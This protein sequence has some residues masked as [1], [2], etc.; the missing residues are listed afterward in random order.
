[1]QPIIGLNICRRGPSWVKVYPSLYGMRLDGTSREAI[2]EVSDLCRRFGISTVA[3][4]CHGMGD[5]I[6]YQL[7][8]RG[9][10]VV[11]IG[12]KHGVAGELLA[13]GIAAAASVELNVVGRPMPDLPVYKDRR[14]NG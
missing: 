6:A 2:E 5:S 9:I 1:M 10:K 8:Q 3:L 12:L 4:D 13:L 11:R 7:E 14:T